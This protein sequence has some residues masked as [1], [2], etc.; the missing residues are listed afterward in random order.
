MPEQFGELWYI[1]C[2]LEELPWLQP[3]CRTERLKGWELPQEGETGIPLSPHLL[4]SQTLLES[5]ERNCSDQ[6]YQVIFTFYSSVKDQLK[7]EFKSDSLWNRTMKY[8]LWRGSQSFQGGDGTRWAKPTDDISSCKLEQGTI[9]LGKGLRYYR[10]QTLLR[11]YVLMG[12]SRH[13][14][15][16]S[17]QYKLVTEW[18]D[19]GSDLSFIIMTCCLGDWLGT[20]SKATKTLRTDI[21]L[22]KLHP[23]LSTERKRKWKC[24]GYCWG[25]K[26]VRE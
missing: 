4:R 2:C 12:N 23:E 18:I 21:E 7:I 14:P 26:K 6:R 8:L 3:H 15:N 16:L 10:W 1:V 22:W 5:W 19:S 13:I 11:L 25:K 24:F 17:F 20:D 9:C